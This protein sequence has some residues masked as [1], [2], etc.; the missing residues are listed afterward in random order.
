MTSFLVMDGD[1]ERGSV[2]F[3]LPTGVVTFLLTDIAGSSRAWQADGDGMAPA[4][5]RHYEIV[6][7]AVVRWGGVRPVEQGEGDSIVAAFSRAT[8]ATAAALDAQRQ[9][10]DELGDRFTVR[11]A[12]HTG[13]AQLR[14]EGNYFGHAVIRCARLRSCGHGCQI[15]LSHTTADL[16]SDRLTDGVALQDL[17]EHRLKDLH[18]PERVFELLHEGLPS[19]GRFPELLSL[20]AFRHNLPAQMTPLI[21]REREIADVTSML[22]GERIVTLI[23]TGGCGKTRLAAEV[24]ARIVDRFPGGVW[25]CEL[26]PLH[27]DGAVFEAL[28]AALGVVQSPGRPLVGEIAERLSSIGPTLAVLDNAE[29]LLDAV[30]RATV[31]LCAR[32]PDL[33]IVTTSREP[34]SIPGEVAWRV[35]SLAVPP[36]DAPPIVDQM[37]EFAAVGL[38]VERAARSRSGFVLTEEN[39]AAVSSIC[40]RLDGIPLAI[41]LAAARVRTLA[42]ERIAAQLD[43]RFRLLTGGAR[44]LLPRQQTLLASVA[45][46]ETL[47]DD[48]ERNALR[49][50]GV[51]VGGFSL[52]AAEAVLGAFDDTDAYEVLD[53]VGRLVDKSLV[54]LDEES[55]RYRMLE[56][57]RSF[58]LAR[59]LDAGEGD[60][61]RDAHLAWAIEF[62]T[63]HDAVFSLEV[64]ARWFDKIT[65]EWPNLNAALDWSIDRPERRCALVAAL[66]GCWLHGQRMVD[67]VS[68]GLDTI[69]RFAA[70]PPPSWYRAVANAA[71]PLGNAEVFDR[72]EPFMTSATHIAREQGD[73]AALVRLEGVALWGRMATKGLTD[74]ILEAFDASYH[75]AARVGDTSTQRNAMSMPAQ[76][77]VLSGRIDEVSV[78]VLA[79]LAGSRL[80]VMEG[81]AAIL[82]GEFERAA[83]RLRVGRE[84]AAAGAPKQ[85]REMVASYFDL[86]E[87]YTGGAIPAQERIDLTDRVGF[88]GMWEGIHSLFRIRRVVVE[89][90]WHDIDELA[91][92]PLVD[93]LNSVRAEAMVLPALLAA[94]RPQNVAAR[95]HALAAAADR[96]RFPLPAIEARLVLTELEHSDEY[97]HDALAS[98]ALHGLV[99]A[100][101]DAIELL[102]VAAHR[103][104]DTERAA[105][106]KAAAL[107]ER[108]RI[109]YRW[110]WPSRDAAFEAVEVPA[111][112]NIDSLAEAVA[113]A[114]RG[115]GDHRRETFGWDALT[116]TELDVAH[117]VASGLTNPQ[118]AEKLHVGTSTVKTHLDHIYAKLGI[119]NR[120]ELAAEVT[121]RA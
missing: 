63:A 86:L 74:E 17:G 46:S 50:L 65:P 79:A 100:Q 1:A 89:R 85:E 29:H 15:L 68:Y 56:T 58:A 31:E 34:L 88:I 112:S 49:R 93:N 84:I 6:D 9:L 111:G 14:D 2:H 54:A 32:V 66:G 72:L 87:A 4:V 120:T 115:R 18:R 64:S 51:F 116:P 44:T 61:A 7:A 12:L 117:R 42:P 3:S 39:A 47:L 77:L 119:K 28:A 52:E 38:F 113:Y 98:A 75:R 20:D 37:E 36:A 99:L 69:E 48:A 118:V 67:A 16:V 110:R 108:E 11:M 104:G 53:L 103:A 62:A 59:L 19:A 27:D 107:A 41:E 40:Q 92:R 106:L 73:E 23:G 33:S 24:G 97:A 35:P 13:E 57:I 45:W 78:E 121:R 91:A 55:G 5:A 102:A 30:A 26:A 70:D 10:L 96:L 76:Q 95:G 43:D 83:D 21:G 94:G 101:I 81:Y 25:W 80:R 8:D 22:E 109:G 71:A 105:R 114:Q 60:I 82:R 90:A